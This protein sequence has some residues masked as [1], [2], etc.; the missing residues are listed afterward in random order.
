MNKLADYEQVVGLAPVRKVRKLAS[1]LSGLKL[2]TV[3]STRVGGGVAEILNRL[4]PLLNEVGINAR[5]EVL[6]GN[7]AFFHLTKRLHNALQGNAISFTAE[8][9]QT[10]LEVQKANADTLNLR[11]D[12]VLIHDP[13]PA[14]LIALVKSQAPWIW[15]CHI[16]LSQ[17]APQAWSFIKDYVESYDASVFTLSCFSR[18]L[19]HPQYLIAPSIDP[20]SE[21]NR[22]L[23]AEEV[24]KVYEELGVPR[25]KP[26]LLQ[27]SRFDHFKDPVGVIDAFKLVRKHCPCRLVLAGGGATDDPEG[28]EVLA[29]VRERAADLQDVHILELETEADHAVNALQRGAD[30]VI[31]KSLR[32]GFGLTVTEALWKG[33]PVIG[34]A[35]GGILT[36]VYNGY[37]GYVVYSVDGCAF[38]IRYLLSSPALR[39]AMG[40][41]GREFVRRNYLITRHLRDYLML[42][43]AVTGRL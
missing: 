21:K 22:E 36:Q 11:G 31:Q 35:A 2:V 16:D 20:F 34:G 7:D 1:E 8:D 29:E 25:D 33:K 32:E 18:Q 19:S 39:K 13:Q 43:Y 30:I 41:R 26:V 9:R 3:N 10:Y 5:W 38:W 23:P 28:E 15:R 6:E 40:E 12:V 37:N 24:E 4:V 42:L 17:P 27:V 14:G